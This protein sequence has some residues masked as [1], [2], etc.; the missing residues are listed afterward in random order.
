MVF[1]FH[2]ASCET[3]SLITVLTEPLLEP[4]DPLLFTKPVIDPVDSLPCLQSLL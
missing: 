2:N 3:R 1:R 4:Q